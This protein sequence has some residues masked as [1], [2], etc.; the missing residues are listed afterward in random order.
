M[1]ET[2]TRTQLGPRINENLVA[3]N[4]EQSS[5]FHRSKTPGVIDST[6]IGDIVDSRLRAEKRSEGQRK[7][8]RENRRQ[9]NNGE[10]DRND[11]C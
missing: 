10:R 3:S 8:Q 7:E 5:N 4:Y 9:E 2:K 6:S 11:A 1:K